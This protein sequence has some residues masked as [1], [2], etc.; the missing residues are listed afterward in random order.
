V[1][2]VSGQTATVS[3]ICPDGS[4]SVSAQ[5]SGNSAQWQ[6]SFTCPPVALAGTCAAIT[7]THQ[8]A[9]L[10]LD[11]T[12]TLTATGSGLASGCGITSALTL[13]F[14]GTK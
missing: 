6:G 11:S 2:A 7:L 14:D 4:G 1:I 13:T 12:G 10:M 8:T 3:A 5:G 9:S